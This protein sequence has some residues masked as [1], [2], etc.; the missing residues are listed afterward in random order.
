MWDV[1]WEGERVREDGRK[2]R[3]GGEGGRVL[4]HPSRGLGLGRGEPSS[5][6]LWGR[7]DPVLLSHTNQLNLSALS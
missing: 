4:E 6:G 3:G 7:G 2:A 1:C 5:R